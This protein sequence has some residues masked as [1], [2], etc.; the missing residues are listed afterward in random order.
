MRRFRSDCSTIE[1]ILTSAI[2]MANSLL[3]PNDQTAR[4]REFIGVYAGSNFSKADFLIAWLIN[5][6]LQKEPLL[7][8]SLYLD[9][10]ILRFRLMKFVFLSLKSLSFENRILASLMRLKQ[11][12]PA[13]LALNNFFRLLNQLC[14]FCLH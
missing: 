6:A 7:S 9:I 4:I 10:Y 11:L 13:S 5:I 1:N 3:M 12:K 14:L 2:L 8:Q